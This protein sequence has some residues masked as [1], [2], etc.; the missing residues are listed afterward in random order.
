MTRFRIPRLLLVLA[1]LMFT[2]LSSFAA[3]G[4][5]PVRPGEFVVRVRPEALKS[6]S[7]PFQDVSE[8]LS[9]M[10]GMKDSVRFSRFNTS[11][12]FATFKVSGAPSRETLEALRQD[13][14]VLYAEPNYIFKALGRGEQNPNDSQFGALWG[15]KNVGQADAA[16]QVGKAGADI[17]VVPVWN[18]GITGDKRIRVAVIDT[19]VDYNHPDLKANVDAASGYNFAGN[20]ADARD[21][22]NHGTHC[23]GTIGGIGNNGVGVT[24]V[25]WNVTII[26]IK[27]LDANGSGSLAGAV[28]SIQ[29]ATKLG[30]DI[31]SNSWGGGPFTQSLYDAI[32]ESR[33]KGILFVAAAGND[34]NDNDGRA[35]YPAGYQIDNV[36]SVAATDNQDKIASFSNYG[37]RTV[38]V[39]A[40]GVK[41]LSTLKNGGYGAM[42]GTSMA[43]PHVAGIAALMRSANPSLTYAQIKD[44]L[45]RSS[46]KVR[47]LSRKSVSGGRVNVYNALHGIFPV[48]DA[49]A[50]NSWK[51]VSMS[52]ESTHPYE[53]GQV[54]TYPIKVPGARFI[55]VVID[56]LDTEAGYDLVE[57][58][59]AD[60]TVV[61][62][63]S[64]TRNGHV[65]DYFSGSEG[66]I[67]LK[68]DGSVNKW[69]FK[70]SRVQAVY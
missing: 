28:Q 33:N 14:A 1:T 44:L 25:N 11:D 12:D 62:S 61:D 69:G 45:I 46:D 48:D 9:R 64:G 18:E 70:I 16:G 7:N 57:T 59:A 26:P 35:T 55:R 47:A 41:I 17:R 51:D 66:R 36:L 10:I 31:M 8:R 23:A 60:G 15:L 38:H 19:G 32:M 40:P 20:N 65:T 49:P 6:S 58:V 52:I 37:R 63:V 43:T 39:A 68:T 34:S 56:Q 3:G 54:K 53:N 24:G 22:H 67:V 27:F 2:A 13:P 50:E 4:S 42:S 5:Y 29:H 30:V 21:D